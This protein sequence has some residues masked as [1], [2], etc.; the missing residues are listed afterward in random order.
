MDEKETQ[1]TQTYMVNILNYIMSICSMLHF[2][3]SLRVKRPVNT[4]LT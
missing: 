4:E 3:R 2:V 1:F